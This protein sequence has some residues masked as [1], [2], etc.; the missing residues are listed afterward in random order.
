MDRPEVVADR[1]RGEVAEM[2]KEP[3]FCKDCKF[4]IPDGNAAWNLRCINPKV[5]REDS[6]ALAS[7]AKM[8]GTDCC[9][10]RSKRGWF[11]A[12]GTRGKQWELNEKEL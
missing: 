7:R 2:T 5:N 1:I 4:A 9:T 11:V 8:R 6:W 12:C 10:E 3:V